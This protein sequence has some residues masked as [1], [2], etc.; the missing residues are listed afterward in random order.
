[1]GARATRSCFWISSLDEGD[2]ASVSFTLEAVWG[3]CT[4]HSCPVP[5]EHTQGTLCSV[6]PA[7]VQVCLERVAFAHMQSQSPSAAERNSCFH[8]T[9]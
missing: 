8:G 3:E 6:D 1:M 2:P 5:S 9:V 7:S 4:F